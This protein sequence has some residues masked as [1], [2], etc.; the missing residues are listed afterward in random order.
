MDVCRVNRAVHHAQEYYPSI[1][2]CRVISLHAQNEGR[3]SIF[4]KIWVLFRSDIRCCRR[5][6]VVTNII[7][8]HVLLLYTLSNVSVLN[9]D[10]KHVYI[11]FL[12]WRQKK[13]Q[14]NSPKFGLSV[15]GY[16]VPPWRKM[17]AEWN[18][19]C[20]VFQLLKTG[21]IFSKIQIKSLYNFCRG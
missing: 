13:K 1:R 19:S 7:L 11:L 21:T 6:M 12:R 14:T 5:D 2:C 16:H 4:F 18:H 8:H 15:L 20:L 3:V 10:V 9:I 17:Q